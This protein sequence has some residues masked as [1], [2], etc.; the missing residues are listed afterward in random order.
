MSFEIK[1]H[2]QLLQLLSSGAGFTM[3]ASLK[4]QHE[5]LQ[6][7]SAAKNSGARINLTGMG[8]KPHHE[9]LQLAVAGKGVITFET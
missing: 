4:P 5:L 2:H 6:L 1:P 8:L 9:L 3:K 7:A